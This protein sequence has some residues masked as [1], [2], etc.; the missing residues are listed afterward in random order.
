[1]GIGGAGHGGGEA[2]MLRGALGLSASAEEL[3]F[4]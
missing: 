4:R 1:V 3:G 2:E